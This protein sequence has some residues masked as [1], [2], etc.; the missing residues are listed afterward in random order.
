MVQIICMIDSLVYVD[1]WYGTIFIDD[2][3]QVD[4]TKIGFSDSNS[5]D[6]LM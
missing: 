1:A 3:L 6:S 4:V 5:L 2:E